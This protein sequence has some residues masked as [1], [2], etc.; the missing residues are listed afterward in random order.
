MMNGL[1]ALTYW[2]EYFGHPTGSKQGILNAIQ[3][4]GAVCSLPIAP[5]LAD[6]IGR[7]LSIFVGSLI[8]VLGAGL[9]SGAR[10]V[11]MFIAGRFFIGLGSGINGIASPLL[12]TELAH[13]N[14]RGKI[15]A[16]Y[17]TFYYFGST[18][19]AWTTYGTLQI[20]SNWSWRLPS[21]LQVAPSAM[22]LCLIYLL[23]ESPRWL[24]R[25]D[26]P[27]EALKILAKYH[28]NDDPH[29]EVIQFEFAEVRAQLQ[30]EKDKSQGRYKDLIT[31]P[32]NRRR[33]FI[34]VC[35]GLFSQ[36]SG[37]GLTGYYLTKVL[38]DVGITNP[39]FQNRL[40]GIIAITNWIEA[41]IFALLVDKVGRRPLFLTSNSGMICTFATWIA[42]TAVQNK[43]QAPGPGK[44]VI[45]MIF[46]HNFFYN[47]CWVSLNLAY[48][49][50]I[51]PYTIRANGVM[52]QSL[53]TNLA[54]FFG[55][56]V[57]PIGIGN[58]GWKFYLLY[59]CWLVVELVVV[60]FFFIETRGATLE[61]ISRTFDGAEAVEELKELALEKAKVEMVEEQD[62]KTQQAPVVN[63]MMA[64]GV[65]V[66]RDSGCCLGMADADDRQQ[67]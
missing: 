67:C 26:R 6:R 56:Y 49:V 1:Q 53:A 21:L 16:V 12:V 5:Y 38:D 52:V 30:R 39:E 18:I 55:Q 36:L 58:A 8:V 9:Q 57:N 66:K 50:E 22:Q 60:Y 62:G 24:I 4:I 31:T 33:L 47:L 44:G 28:A 46:L 37:T 20:Q 61:E 15:T 29:D 63:E 27:D 34:C 42:L 48:P 35:C 65:E 43:T 3:S 23:P 19:A 40:N 2:Q 41:S 59:Q 14:Q 32:G 25:K 45:V 17:N 11:G 7:K 10:D 64:S 51:L 13:P 54:L